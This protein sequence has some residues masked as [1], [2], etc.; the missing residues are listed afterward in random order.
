MISQKNKD[1]AK[2]AMKYALDKGCSNARV[3]VYS[4]TSNS[5]E[6]RDTQIDKIEQ[7]TER[8]MN[9]QLFVDGRF[10]SY[11]TNRFE[12]KE[13]ERYIAKG[14]ETTRLLA[15]DEFR[16]LPN[17]VLY[18][19]GD[20]KGLDTFDPAGEK[21][22]I[23]DK[24]SLIKDTTTEVYGTDQLLISVS[25]YYNEGTSALYMVTSNGFEG[26]SATS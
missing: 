16:K 20:G 6:Y 26:E 9:I 17:P 13:L 14:V 11:S 24:L 1:L 2:W 21:I 10:A 18:Y 3:S 7:S 4:N 12:K 22:S 23:D 8:G 19:N 5:L 15:K 25:S